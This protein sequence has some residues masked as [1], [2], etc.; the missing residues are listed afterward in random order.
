MS[1]SIYTLT[2]LYSVSWKNVDVYEAKEINPDSALL[3]TIQKEGV[4][5]HTI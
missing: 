5:T 1:D 2:E 4:N 3:F